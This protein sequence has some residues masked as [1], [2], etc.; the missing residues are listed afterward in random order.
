MQTIEARV[1]VGP[2]RTLS[3]QLPVDVL[4]G[5]YEVVLVLNQRAAQ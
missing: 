2:D 1:Q 4:A 3:M 5:E